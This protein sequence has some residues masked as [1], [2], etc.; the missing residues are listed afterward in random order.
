MKERGN[1]GKSKK[2]L[3]KI[4][5]TLG[6]YEEEEELTTE[7]ETAA[8]TEDTEKQAP[9]PASSF[10]RSGS[11]ALAKPAVKAPVPEP[12]APVKPKKSLFSRSKAAKAEKKTINMPLSKKQIKVVVIEPTDFN[13]SQKV[14]DYLRNNQP[15]VVNFETTDRNTKK[16]M[17]DFIYGTIYALNG[18]IKQIGNNILVCAPK[19]VDIDAETSLYGEK[20]GTSKWKK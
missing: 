2:L 6:L 17:T 16:R 18:S 19:N 7:E 5:D 9:R 3:E 13:D 20:G 11:R 14:A 15:V 8:E 10:P 12:A 1:M 4:S